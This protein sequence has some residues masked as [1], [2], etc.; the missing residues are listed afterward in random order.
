[1]NFIAKIV[2]IISMIVTIAGCVHTHIDEDKIMEEQTQSTE[3][4]M[5]YFSEQ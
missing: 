4:D 5:R 2:V 3:M 1:M